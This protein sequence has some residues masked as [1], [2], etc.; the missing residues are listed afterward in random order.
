MNIAQK[1]STMGDDVPQ[2][3]D[4]LMYMKIVTQNNP[5]NE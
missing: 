2:L 3:H 1:D 5:R 4:F